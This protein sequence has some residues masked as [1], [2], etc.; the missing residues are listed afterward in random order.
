MKAT[1]STYQNFK[2]ID[3]FQDEYF[4]ASAGSSLE[5]DQEFWQ[6][7]GAAYPELHPEMDTARSWI[8]LIKQQPIKRQTGSMQ[9]RWQGIQNQLQDYGRRQARV[10]R[11]QA[12]IRWSA[13][14][15]ALFL[16]VALFYEVNQ[17]GTKSTK[18]T[19]GQR[20]EVILPDES[21]IDL[22]SNSTL[23]YVRD[24]KSDKPREV[25]LT[26]EA[27]F[28][29]KHTAV[30]NRLREND[31]FVVR[32]ADLALTVLGTK[33]NVKERRGRVEVTLFEGSLQITGGN[34]IEKMLRP[35]ETFVYDTSV[36]TE[37][38]LNKDMAKVSSWTRGELDIEHANLSNIVE[39]LEDNYG[40]KVVLTDSGLLEKRLTGTI[41]MTNVKDI[42]FVLK[43]TMDVNIQVNDK[44]ITINS[45]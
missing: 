16:A 23:S 4:S 21:L 7:L 26:G 2:A 27:M 41:P 42:L 25:W 43:H 24:W 3:F 8:L 15:A 11:M 30:R 29:V 37:T 31:R 22:N 39:V 14:I 20:R 33:F 13:S 35:G 40:Y 36:K 32:V 19:F 17:F 18:T 44:E 34:G 6:E 28:E 12:V 10:R 5:A 38:L 1:F 9:M 45:K